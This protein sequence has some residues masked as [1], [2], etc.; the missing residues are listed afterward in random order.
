VSVSHSVPCQSSRA[1]T[2][3]NG[4]LEKADISGLLSM[5]ASVPDPRSPQGMQYSLEFIL[6]V[7]VVAT[8]AGAANYRELGSHA[9]DMPQELLKKLGAKWSW[10]KLRYK[11]PSKSAIRYVLTRIDAAVLDTITCTWIFAQAGKECDRG[12]W[13][14]ALDGK[15]LRG[16]W[17]DE[18]DKVTLFSAMLHD[19]AVT[20]AQ[21]RVPD[22]TNEITQ[23][24]AILE[25]VEIPEGISALFTMDA[26]HAQKETAE[27]I[28]G[29]PGLDYL[30]TVK[31]NQPTLQR[32]VFEAVLPLLRGAPDNVVEE[33]SRGRIK[34]WS[35]WI[36]GADIDFPHACQVVF[37]RREVFEISGDRISK[38]NALV[39]TSRKPGEMTAADASRHTRNHW[40]IENKS[41][42]VRD[43]VYREDHG[44]A[45][46]GEG[47]HALASLRNLSAG[48][49]RLKKENA[50]KET[51]QWVNR[52]QSRALKFMTT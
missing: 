43:T 32:A 37:I 31:G 40:G 18:N 5:L 33:R 16:A 42:Y 26:A 25:A 1:C 13:V 2:T 6:A 38:E 27:V 19:E 11:H 14:I 46:A 44:Q 17:T 23:A 4:D 20:V 48:L 28:G 7:C 36:A 3:G 51:T 47:P 45:W 10:F 34:K 41:H 22:G 52:D 24:E 12:E 35:C 49:I 39:L 8:L 9:A 50:I 21:V 29:K 15:V 30:V